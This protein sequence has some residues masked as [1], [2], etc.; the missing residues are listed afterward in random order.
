MYNIFFEPSILTINQ[1]ITFSTNETNKIDSNDNNYDIVLNGQKGSIS[2]YK[3][4]HVER[5]VY[6]Q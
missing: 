1:F 4:P 2:T 3:C 6:T 5:D